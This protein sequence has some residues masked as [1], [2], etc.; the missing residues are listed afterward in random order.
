MV[1][2]KIGVIPGVTG[3]TFENK[4]HIATAC[5]FAT[6]FW[7][8]WDEFGALPTVQVFE[9]LGDPTKVINKMIGHGRQ[10]TKPANGPLL[11][12]PGSVVI[13][14]ENGQ[15]EHSTI[16]LDQ[17]T[18]AGYNQTNWF[19][20]EGYSHKFSTHLTADIMW[21]SNSEVQ[22]PGRAK[23]Y[24]LFMVPEAMAKAVVLNFALTGKS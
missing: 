13:F 10:L 11:L 6:F 2:Q 8:Y 15:A 16:A 17:R 20:T 24:K 4:P 12:I 21:I 1:I 3:A 14:A 22:R 9:T 18:I 7:L 23:T 19:K 5:H